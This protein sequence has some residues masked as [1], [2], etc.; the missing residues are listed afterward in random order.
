MLQKAWG[1]EV[2]CNIFFEHME[3]IVIASNNKGKIGEIRSILTDWNILSLSDVNFDRE[4][5][6][7]YHTFEDNA[8]IKA[9]TVH[10]FCGK[11][12][13]ADDSGIC[14]EALDDAPGVYSARYA[15]EP[16]D[17]VKNLE[18]LLSELKGQENRNAF[19]KAVLCLIWNE[20]TYFFEGICK[21]TILEAP[22]GSGGFGYDPIF[23]PEG[24]DL[25]FAELPLEVKNKISHRGKALAQLQEFI[26]DNKDQ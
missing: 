12:V 19:Y 26:A 10:E 18:K 25:S 21:G 11:N 22:R 2:N 7:P 24:Y 5:E 16:S 3:E 23:V 20:E 13:L 4:I 14:V 15:G 8:H 6:E 1:I 9:Q 17:D